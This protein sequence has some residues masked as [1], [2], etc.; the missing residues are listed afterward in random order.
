MREMRKNL[1]VGGFVLAAC[2]L[3]IWTLLSLRP[4]VGDQG[5]T[6]RA[7]FSDINKIT[8]GTP[9]NYAGRPVGEVV[10]I[11][12]VEDPRKAPADEY[13]RRYVYRVVMKVDSS[14]QLYNTDRVAVTTSGL[15]GEKSIALIPQLPPPGVT[16]ESVN[17]EV[18]LA[19]SSDAL[20]SVVR[21]VGSLADSL[22]ETFRDLGGLLKD[23]KDEFHIAI[24]E[25]GQA[26]RQV[27]MAI[28]QL[29]EQK[30]FVELPEAVSHLKSI[31]TA[32][33]KPA[34]IDALITDLGGL[35]HNL[36][37]TSEGLERGEGTLGALLKKEDLYEQFQSLIKQAE[38]AVD[39]INR[40]GLLFHNNKRWQRMQ[41]PQATNC[42]DSGEPL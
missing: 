30:L 10:E 33:D 17:G 32:A 9:V 19:D 34:E 6:V 38:R 12:P 4:R 40:Y 2:A 23:N 1:I 27:R 39:S 36:N 26:M 25:F 5:T 3:I 11:I 8:V 29:E 37:L 16:P 14:V 31:L 24:D 42:G 18:M 28:A 13:G 35:A 20:D 7:L 22:G 21:Q 15:L 41:Q